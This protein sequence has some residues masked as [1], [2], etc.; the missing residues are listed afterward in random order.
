M[1]RESRLQIRQLGEGEGKVTGYASIFDSFAND[2][3]ECFAP[4]CFAEAIRTQHTE[5]IAAGEPSRLGVCWGHSWGEPVARAVEVAEDAKGLRFIDQMALI[6]KEP[7]GAPQ[8]NADKW[9]QVKAGLVNGVSIEFDG[10]RS[11]FELLDED[12]ARDLGFTGDYD[13]YWP[14]RRWTKV[15]LYGWS[16]VLHPAQNDARIIET[17]AAKEGEDMDEEMVKKIVGEVITEKMKAMEDRLA[18]LEAVEI[19]VKPEEQPMPEV[20]AMAARIAQ[21]EKRAADAEFAAW[22]AQTPAAAKLDPAAARH[23]YDAPPQVRAA[24]V[25]DLPVDAS[26]PSLPQLGGGSQA[27]ESQT[28]PATATEAWAKLKRDIPDPVKRAERWAQIKDHYNR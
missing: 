3:A 21:L 4:G 10:R 16:Y 25:K 14:P 26:T 17:R 11:A 2:R 15:F 19:E 8:T 20:A 13:P 22:R 9:E 6:G 1:R 23:I 18:K 27:S 12:Q 5:P 7:D 28:L 24:L